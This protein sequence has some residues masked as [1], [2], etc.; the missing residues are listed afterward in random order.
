MSAY[1]GKPPKSTGITLTEVKDNGEVSFDIPERGIRKETVEHFG[2][3]RLFSV[4]DQKLLGY[5]FPVTKKGEITGYI[6]YNP[7]R[8]KKD[9]RF[10]T[11]GDVNIESELLGQSSAT[12]GKKIFIVEGCFDLLSAFQSLDSCKPNGF[13]GKPTVVSP[14]LGIGNISSGITNA[15]QHIANNIDFVN[16]YNEKVVCFDNDENKEINVG[17][18]GVQ[19]VALILKDFKNCVLPVN[20]C[21]DML[22]ENGEKELYINNVFSDLS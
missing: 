12:N 10:S 7:E 9:G 2:I 17:Q 22:K 15:R 14:A 18:E 4:V 13:T 6:H 16:K 20:D 1:K 8:S 11:V 21:N 19:D 3:R 5:F